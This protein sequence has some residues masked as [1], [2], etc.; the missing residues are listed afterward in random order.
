MMRYAAEVDSKGD[1]LRVL[2]VPETVDDGAAYCE[3]LGLTGAWRDAPELC[4]IGQRYHAGRFY[5]HWQPIAGADTGPEGAESGWPVGAEVWHAGAVWVSRSQFNDRDPLDVPSTWGRADGLY[6]VPAGWQYQVGEE[7]REDADGP[8]HR[9][10][11]ATAFPPSADAAAYVEITGPGG[12]VVAPAVGEWAPNVAYGAGDEASYA[13]IVYVIAT[14]H[15]SQVGWEP[16][17]V[18]ALWAVA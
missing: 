12:E 3:A 10:T 14:P 9:V 15:T 2:V 11:R 4:A 16:P 18:P 17:N 5:T 7:L 8:W 13:G 1:V 6:V